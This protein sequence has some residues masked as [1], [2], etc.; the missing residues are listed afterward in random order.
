[1]ITQAGYLAK[2]YFY[3]EDDDV[4][5]LIDKINEFDPRYTLSLFIMTEI[6]FINDKIK[7][8]MKALENRTIDMFWIDNYIDREETKV[9]LDF[10]SSPKV[11]YTKYSL[12]IDTEDVVD[13]LNVLKNRYSF[14]N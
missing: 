5:L 1:M 9:V 2:F 6:S 12:D 4:E 7:E 10:L 14:I 8:L 3:G 13:A 11:S